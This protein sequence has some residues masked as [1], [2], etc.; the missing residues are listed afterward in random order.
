MDYISF[1]NQQIRIALKQ[2]DSELISKNVLLLV[3]GDK[4][5][6]Y[7]LAG[8]FRKIGDFCRQGI[9]NEE[10]AMMRMW[11]VGNLDIEKVH[12]DGAPSFVLT[13]TGLEIMTSIP[14]ESWF[15]ALISPL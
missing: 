7:K 6:A 12:A 14:K 2:H 8:W 1:N 13:F 9:L 4:E 11:Q 5:K 10:I 15:S 3:N